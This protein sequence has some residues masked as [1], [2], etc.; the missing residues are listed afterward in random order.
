LSDWVDIAHWENCKEMARPGVIVEIRNA[1]GK[2]LFTP[3]VTP[4]PAMPWD[5]NSPP[6]QF[7]AVAEP[8]PQHSDP[9]PPPKS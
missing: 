7:R 9:L 8:K 2:S 5:W 6:L 3:C 4:L 1:E